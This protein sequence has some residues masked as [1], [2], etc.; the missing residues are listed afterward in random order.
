MAEK[1]IPQGDS[2][3]MWAKLPKLP[4]L[5]THFTMKKSVH[6]PDSEIVLSKR[7]GHGI[8]HKNGKA[9]WTI[10]GADT[11]KLETFT[12]YVWDVR[13]K[14]GSRDPITVDGGILRIS[15]TVRKSL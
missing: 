10:T 4:N 9:H 13:I 8:V 1:T 12:M 15:P 7:T 6:D 3:P 11:L 14:Y 2:L 5:T